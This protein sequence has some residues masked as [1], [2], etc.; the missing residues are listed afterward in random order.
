[1]HTK[2]SE[3]FFAGLRASARARGIEL[4]DVRIGGSRDLPAALPRAMKNSQ[5]VWLVGDSTLT[6]GAAFEYA[7]KTSLAHRV[8]LIAP[9]DGLVA[10][11][12]FLGIVNDRAAMAR[13]AVGVANAA[14][15][16]LPAGAA[17]DVPAGRLVVNEVLA[18]RW[19]VR[20]SG[21]PR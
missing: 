7:V 2:N 16:G 6:E 4:V 9:G 1:M 17:A 18:R 21:G 5:A 13:H 20:V 19:G 10:R 11:G 3:S 8:P 12:V 15:K 14:A